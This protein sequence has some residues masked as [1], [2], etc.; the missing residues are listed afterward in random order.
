MIWYLIQALML[1]LVV[2]DIFSKD[3]KR[4]YVYTLLYV[5]MFLGV[6]FFSSKVHADEMKE[7]GQACNFV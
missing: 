7:W 1:T 3:R 5:V 6:W 2:V 4:V